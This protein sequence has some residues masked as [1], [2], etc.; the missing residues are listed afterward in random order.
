[1]WKVHRRHYLDVVLTGMLLFPDTP[2]VG[3]GSI[4]CKGVFGA[5]AE[6]DLY[7]SA[8]GSARWV[9]LYVPHLRL[10]R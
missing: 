10:L 9:E 8:A 1:M 6:K 5:M 3:T 7:W 4:W 2:G